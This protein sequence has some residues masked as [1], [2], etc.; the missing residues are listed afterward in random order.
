MAHCLP[1]L[2]TLLPMGPKHL[3]NEPETTEAPGRVNF[4][5]VIAANL[6]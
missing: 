5:I 2:S 3:S 1:E 4:L 6:T